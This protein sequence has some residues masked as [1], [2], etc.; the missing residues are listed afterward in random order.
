VR[1]RQFLLKHFLPL[2]ADAKVSGS[3]YDLGPYPGLG[4]NESKSVVVGEV[5]E[6]DDE[7]LNKL[8]DL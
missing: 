6:V 4:L 1:E 8:D 3:L 7:T 5:Y 2:V